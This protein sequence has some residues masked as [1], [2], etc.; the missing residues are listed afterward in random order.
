MDS[1][2]NNLL[3]E[4]RLTGKRFKFGALL[5]G[6]KSKEIH[7]DTLVITYSHSSNVDRFNSEL[8]DPV[9]KSDM[10]SIIHKTLNKEY[11]VEVRLDGESSSLKTSKNSKG[12]SNL[13]KS[14][15]AMGALII[16]EREKN[17]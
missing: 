2:W 16:E 6:A 13:V 17:I 12:S 15:Q 11:A 4:L 9:V 8:E 14:A 10:L 1:E 7:D 3:R 5:R